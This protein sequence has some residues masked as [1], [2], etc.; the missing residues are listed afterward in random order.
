MICGSMVNIQSATAENRQGKKE[1]KKEK[2][3]ETTAAKYNGLPYW[4][5]IINKMQS[6]NL[7]HRPT[8]DDEERQTIVRSKREENSGKREKERY[9]IQLL[10]LQAIQAR[11]SVWSSRGQLL[12]S[13]SATLV[14]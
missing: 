2:K 13:W 4:S 3:I 1:K 12:R 11:S 14:Q 7:S 6:F 5:S 10:Q 8:C 9:S